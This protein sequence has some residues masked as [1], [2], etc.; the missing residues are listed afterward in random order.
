MRAVYQKIGLRHMMDAFFPSFQLIWRSS[1]SISQSRASR[2]HVNVGG[3]AIWRITHS[4]SFLAVKALVAQFDS[5]E[6][7]AKFRDPQRFWLKMLNW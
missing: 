5:Q 7:L 6:A 2:E 3:Q 1:G 4:F